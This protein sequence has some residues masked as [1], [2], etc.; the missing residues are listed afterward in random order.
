MTRHPANKNTNQLKICIN[1]YLNFNSINW[2][3]PKSFFC[4][5]YLLVKSC[6][7]CSHTR[8]NHPEHFWREAFQKYPDY[9][10]KKFAKSLKST[11]EETHPTSSCCPIAWTLFSRSYLVTWLGFYVGFLSKDLLFRDW[12]EIGCNWV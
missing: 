8:V 6:R 9:Y 1:K 3:K 10:L 7:V 5:C 4:L 12:V 11:F 2:T